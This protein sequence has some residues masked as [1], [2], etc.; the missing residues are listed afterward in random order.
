MITFIRLQ[1]FYLH[2]FCN[3]YATNAQTMYVNCA[4]RTIYKRKSGWPLIIFDVATG[5]GI[6]ITI[7]YA[8]S[9]INLH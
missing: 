9:I 3:K 7:F 5:Q 1:M 8:K 4:S 6:K 2:A